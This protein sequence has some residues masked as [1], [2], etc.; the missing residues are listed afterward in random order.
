MFSKYMDTLLQ[1]A[2]YKKDS[3]GV[4]I[5]KIPGHKG[6][7]TQGDTFEEARENLIDLIE[8]LTIDAIK[9]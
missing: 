8:T 2:I 1:K 5:A 6:Y 3:N 4:I 9:S 7:Y